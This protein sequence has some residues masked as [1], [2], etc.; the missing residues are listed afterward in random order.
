VTSDGHVLISVGHRKIL[1]QQ[2][3]DTAV[4]SKIDPRTLSR[5]GISPATCVSICHGQQSGSDGVV[6]C[7]RAS[8]SSHW[9]SGRWSFQ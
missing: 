7:V 3:T 5:N 6:H 2:R 9:H 1:S 4:P 8:G